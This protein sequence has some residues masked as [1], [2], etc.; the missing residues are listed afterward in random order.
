MDILKVFN[1]QPWPVKVGATL[2]WWALW[3]LTWRYGPWS[4]AR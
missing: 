3:F 1:R 4:K 2:A